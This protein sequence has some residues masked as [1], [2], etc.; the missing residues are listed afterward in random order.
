MAMAGKPADAA[1]AMPE[2]L[3]WP[4]VEHPDIEYVPDEE[5]DAQDLGA[6]NRELN[7]CRARVFRVSRELK[8][9]ER[10]FASAKMTYTR[11]MRR[12]L[13]SVSGGSAETRKALAELQCEPY[14]DA[15]VISEQVVAEWKKRATD[16]RDDLKAVE[17]L[18]HNVR[19]QIDIR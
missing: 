11:Q 14:E 4:Q 13:V 1:P 2:D 10:E 18:S 19:A 15:V 6:V 12:A 16:A 8:T 7:R 17:N 3:A 9:A 5:F